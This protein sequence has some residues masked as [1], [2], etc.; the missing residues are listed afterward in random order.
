MK[1]PDTPEDEQLRLAKLRSL[2]LLDT[3]HDSRFDRLTQL[4]QKIF[5][6]PIAMVSLVDEHR[7]W[8]KSSAGIQCS[9]ASRSVSFCGHAILGSDVFI[10]PDALEDERFHDNPLVL[11][12][13]HIRFYAGCPLTVD[14]RT[15]G[16]LCIVDQVPRTLD[17]E[18]IGILRDLA[19]IVEQEVTS[20]LLA[21]K[22]GLTGLKNRR[23]F[24]A[25]AQQSLQLCTRQ[26]TPVSLLYIDLNDF[27]R[28]NQ[29]HGNQAGDEILISLADRIMDVCRDSDVVARLGGDEFVVLLINATREQAEIVVQRINKALAHDDRLSNKGYAITFSFGITAY[30]PERHETIVELLADG[31]ML[32]EE[33]KKLR[34]FHENDG[35]TSEPAAS[36]ADGALAGFKSKLQ[37]RTG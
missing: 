12:E 29:L 2:C 8:S 17:E 36:K 16:T 5:K 6:A 24:L 21:T 28:I 13:P 9:E 35:E 19:R 25:L 15:I 11:G 1:T 37:E 4:A 31:E 7:Q 26:A 23:G 32:I 20:T 14:H 10:V 33:I 27:K 22:D 3:G 18:Q 30:Q 34:T